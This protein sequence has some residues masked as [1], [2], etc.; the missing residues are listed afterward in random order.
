MNYKDTPY[1]LKLL[2]IIISNLY[3]STGGTSGKE[4]A[5]QCR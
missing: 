5:C 2:H 4:S 3:Q 1:S